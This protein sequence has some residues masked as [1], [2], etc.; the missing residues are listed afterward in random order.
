GES[1]QAAVVYLV[2]FKNIVDVDIER[3]EN[4]GKSISYVQVVTSRR[5]I[6]ILD[7]VKGAHIQLPMSELLGEQSD[8]V[9]VL[10]QNQINGL[11]GPILG[12]SL[13]QM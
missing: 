13:Y 11:P 10:V 9:M 3:G 6:G 1:G 4:R 8:G 2:T 5:A 12:A 7:P